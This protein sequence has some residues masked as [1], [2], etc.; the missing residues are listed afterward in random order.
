MGAPRHSRAAALALYPPCPQGRSVL[1]AP[2]ASA[3]IGT[4]G[5]VVRNC[6]SKQSDTQGWTARQHA[7]SMAAGERASHRVVH[8]GQRPHTCAQLQA[9]RALL[10]LTAACTCRLHST[11]R[12]H[13]VHHDAAEEVVLLER[14]E[15]QTIR[16]SALRHA[17]RA[18]MHWWARPEPW[19]GLCGTGLASQRVPHS[20]VPVF[21]KKDGH[22]EVP[23]GATVGG[24]RKHRKCAQR[25]HGGRVRCQ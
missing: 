14:R 13:S 5:P 15:E 22:V 24:G 25:R 16:L 7:A 2:I 17:A 4:A 18:H 6:V 8:C 19:D 9:L 12:R 11:D 10:V 21:G 20:A 23:G 1:Q 3:S